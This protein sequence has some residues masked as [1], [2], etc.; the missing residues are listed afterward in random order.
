MSSEQE[1]GGHFDQLSPIGANQVTAEG[2]IVPAAPAVPRRDDEQVSVADP[3]LPPQY[4]NEGFQ[5]TVQQ[6]VAAARAQLAQPASN[7]DIHGAPHFLRNVDDVERC[8]QDGEDWPCTAFRGMA[9][10]AR[11][12]QFATDALSVPPTMAEA[13]QAAGMDPVE[14]QARL[15]QTRGL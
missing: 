14:F 4:Q 7:V 5:E 1:T 9:E 13:A 11:R 8:G 2:V 10:E 15:R 3:Q 12:A 6:Q